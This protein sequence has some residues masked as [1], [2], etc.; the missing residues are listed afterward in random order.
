M[1]SLVK[2]LP[3]VSF[4]VDYFL[5]PDC[6]QRRFYFKQPCNLRYNFLFSL[7][8]RFS[9]HTIMNWTSTFRNPKNSVISCLRIKFQKN[10]TWK[11]VVA[12]FNKSGRIPRKR[13]NLDSRI[14]NHK[15][16]SG[17]RLSMTK[18]K[19]WPGPLRFADV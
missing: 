16:C 19:S 1:H 3:L 4:K 8:M 13:W 7:V 17:S 5:K 18:M 2:N 6:I 9:K 15:W 10:P 11:R 12:P 14:W